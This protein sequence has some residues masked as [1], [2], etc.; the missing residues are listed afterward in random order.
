[1]AAIFAIVD[2]R[3]GLRLALASLAAGTGG[4]LI[5][6]ELASRQPASQPSEGVVEVAEQPAPVETRVSASV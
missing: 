3:S 2:R 4:A 6:S 5:A 1:M